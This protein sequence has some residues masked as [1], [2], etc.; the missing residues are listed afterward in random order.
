MKPQ[1]KSI[2]AAVA[3][4]INSFP[5]VNAIDLVTNGDFE[6]NGGLGQLGGGISF[7]TGWTSA[8]PS[9]G[10]PTAFNFIANNTADSVGFPSIY[11]PPNIFLWGPGNGIN[12]G[13]TGS[14]NGGYFLVAAADYGQGAISQ[15]ITGLTPGDSYTLEYE[16]A[17]AQEVGFFGATSEYWNVSIASQTFN[18]PTYNLP[19]QGFS[20]WMNQTET[21]TATS[22]TEIL[23]FLAMGSPSGLP[24]VLLLDGV[25]ITPISV[26]EPSTMALGGFATLMVGLMARRKRC[27]QAR[28]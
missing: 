2:V 7:A 22:A 23:S 16:W 24:P 4:M 14:P 15:T 28:A 17:A 26:P 11:S 8:T 27:R 1:I 20:G 21:F 18:S 19:S 10:P 5:P 6:S 25:K 13:F 12:N 3:I 9:T